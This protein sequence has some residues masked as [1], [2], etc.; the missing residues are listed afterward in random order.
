MSSNP[1]QNKGVKVKPAIHQI[2]PRHIF[3]TN[4]S[5]SSFTVGSPNYNYLSDNNIVI[6]KKT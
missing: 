3:D 4:I 5:N 2:D 1:V 6:L